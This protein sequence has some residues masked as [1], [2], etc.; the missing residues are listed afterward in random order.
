MRNV[1]KFLGV[2][3]VVIAVVYFVVVI[4][5]NVDTAKDVLYVFFTPTN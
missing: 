1:A 2:L 3:L 4:T 5:D